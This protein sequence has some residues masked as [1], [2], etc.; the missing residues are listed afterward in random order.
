MAKKT[1]ATSVTF[2]PRQVAEPLGVNSEKV[3]NWIRNGEL[4]AINVGDRQRPRWRIPKES[5]DDFLKRRESSPPSTPR[6]RHS[7]TVRN[8]V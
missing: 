7:T 3:R 1:K 2:S 8:Y 4:I 6:R 5:L